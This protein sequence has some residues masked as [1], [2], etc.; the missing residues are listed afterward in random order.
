MNIGMLSTHLNTGG[1]VSYL[2]T[3]SRGLIELGHNVHIVTSGGNRQ[4][5]FKE[6]G[7]KVLNLNIRT[8]SELSPKIYLNIGRLGDY[9]YSNN[10]DIIHAH[11][12][13]TQ[14]MAAIIYERYKVPYVTTCHG[15]FT[16]KWAR[17][18]WP[19]WGQKVIAIS[20]PVKDHLK[21]DFKVSGQDIE[22][23]KSGIELSR[24][25]RVDNRQKSQIRQRLGIK[26][27]LT[28]GIIARLSDVKGQDILLRA[29]KSVVQ[30]KEVQLLLIGEGPFKGQLLKISNDLKFK[31]EV[32]FI[33]NSG[34]IE[35][36]MSALDIFCMPSRQEGLGLSIME[37]QACGLPVVAS[38]VGGIPELIEHGQTGVLVEKENES[39]LAEALIDLLDCKEKRDLIAERAYQLAQKKY[40]KEEMVKQTLRVYQ[41]CLA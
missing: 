23:I 32:V 1:I 35:E 25:K 39:A 41:G 40:S 28:V 17:T 36:Y 38:N 26:D 37:A 20:G 22:Q 29:F 16:A 21:N 10:M 6:I 34:N 30:K 4:E 5:D 19:C 14:V 2:F 3:L 9:C 7:A 33:N 27:K 24:F 8:K 12:R 13:V 18:L 11:T 31:D 15:Y